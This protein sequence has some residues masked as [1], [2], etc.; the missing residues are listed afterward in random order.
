MVKYSLSVND[1]RAANL[2]GPTND[3]WDRLGGYLLKRC[4]FYIENNSA[5]WGRAATV[6]LPNEK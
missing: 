3:F 5:P 2:H 1:F 6:Y 4:D